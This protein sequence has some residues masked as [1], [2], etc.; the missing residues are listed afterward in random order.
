MISL[1]ESEIREIAEKAI[2]QLG[3]HATA[4]NIEKVVHETVEKLS[5]S[6]SSTPPQIN[7]TIKTN[8]QIDRVIV[9]AFGKNR[10]GILAEMTKTLAETDCDIVDLSQKILNQFFTVM[11][12]VDISQ[13]NLS[14]EEIKSALVK[15]GE[16]L[17]L[18]VVVQHEQIF[19]TMHR[20]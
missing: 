7:S 6:F 10:K 20:V 16:V 14:F 13:S 18:T 17:D 8:H 5:D 1:T 15:S 11:L 12:I 2:L 4:T 3:E 9:T 19:K